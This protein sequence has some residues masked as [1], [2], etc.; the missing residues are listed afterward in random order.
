MQST[1]QHYLP[2]HTNQNHLAQNH[3]QP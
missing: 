1:L 2:Y 3:L